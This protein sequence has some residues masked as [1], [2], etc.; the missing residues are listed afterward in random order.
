MEDSTDFKKALRAYRNGFGIGLLIGIGICIYF[1]KVMLFV[2]ILLA[3][4]I[5]SLF[6]DHKI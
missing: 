3:L 1:G 6:F 2:P 5:G 4:V